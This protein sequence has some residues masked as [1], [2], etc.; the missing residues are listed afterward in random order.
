M[1]PT[2][3]TDALMAMVRNGMIASTLK[4]QNV[5][6]VVS[7]I[8][9]QR[10][11]A[12]ECAERVIAQANELQGQVLGY[13]ETIAALEE[14]CSTNDKLR[15]LLGSKN[16]KIEALQDKLTL[17]EKATRILDGKLTQVESQLAAKD[18]YPADDGG[19]AFPG[20][21]PEI[22]TLTYTNGKTVDVKT[23]KHVPCAGMSLRDWFAGMALQGQLAA[24]R[25]INDYTVADSV[26]IAGC[27]VNQL[28]D[29]NGKEVMQKPEASSNELADSIESYFE[30]YANKDK[31]PGWCSR[32]DGARK[33]IESAIDL[34]RNRKEGA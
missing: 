17:S 15:Q 6:R 33:R 28:A 1:K 2:P 31:K 27:L 34:V 13:R 24:G 26:T 14:R 23:G 5:E 10:D 20:K 25:P 11:D 7:L 29:R 21:V 9:N 16:A 4:L 8:E 3:E 12:R 18:G 22:Q 19:P 32:L 30:I